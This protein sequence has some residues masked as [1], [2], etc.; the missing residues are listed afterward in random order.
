MS[1]LWI[2]AGVGAWVGVT[3]VL[4]NLALPEIK[5]YAR[6][7]RGKPDPNGVHIACRDCGTKLHLRLEAWNFTNNRPHYIS[8]K[9]E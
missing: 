8:L 3:L 6:E 4:I 5:R 7:L 2:G 9:E 1:E